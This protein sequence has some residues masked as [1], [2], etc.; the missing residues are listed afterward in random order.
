MTSIIVCHSLRSISAHDLA[1]IDAHSPS[2]ADF[3]LGKIS[4]PNLEVHQRVQ[5]YILKLS[6]R[7]TCSRQAAQDLVTDCADFNDH[8][9]GE[10][11]LESIKI[12]YA[13]RL[14]VCELEEAGLSVPQDCRREV[15]DAAGGKLWPL[16]RDP[17]VALVKCVKALESRPQS[18]TSYSN[19]RQNILLVCQASRNEVEREKLLSLFNELASSNQ[20]S[21]GA[22]NTWLAY[23]EDQLAEKQALANQLKSFMTTFL[24]DLNLAQSDVATSIA[25]ANIKLNVLE[26]N[27]A[28]TFSGII[29]NVTGITGSLISEINA[30]KSDLSASLL[31]IAAQGQEIAGRHHDE[32]RKSMRL[33]AELATALGHL[34]VRQNEM[35]DQ[36]DHMMAKVML[37]SQGHHRNAEAILNRSQEALQ[38]V[39][40][41]KQSASSIADTVQQLQSYASCFSIMKAWLNRAIFILISIGMFAAART[42]TTQFNGQCG[43]ASIF[44]ISACIAFMNPAIIKLYL[45]AFAALLTRLVAIPLTLLLL[46]PL[47]GK[48]AQ[49]YLRSRLGG[50]KAELRPGTSNGTCIDDLFFYHYI[51]ATGEFSLTEPVHD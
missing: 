32:L 20:E 39:T 51:P 13:A 33:S 40:Y 50:S 49:I 12:S 17:Q 16:R 26:E 3:I 46:V 45:P 15:L 28:K 41:L 10:P 48:V 29:R 18:W 7:P 9:Q 23:A 2:K 5:R 1:H 38:T 36:V 37:Y 8:K 35:Y 21:Q 34:H 42:C 6:A 19:N 30:V 11:K 24:K 4:H 27:S 44:M 43:I 25:D 31:A 22:L 47:L 14:A